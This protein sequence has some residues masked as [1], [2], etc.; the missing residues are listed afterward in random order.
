[1]MSGGIEMRKIEIDNEI[2]HF[3]DDYKVKV[4]EQIQNVT[5]KLQKLA[6]FVSEN[7]HWTD[8]YA[9]TNYIDMMI[10]DYPNLLVLEPKDWQ[11][12]ISKYSMVL[13][14]EPNMLIKEVN[15]RRK[16]DGI[17]YK[18]KFYERILE[19]LGY[20]EARLILGPIHQDMGL[21]TCVYCNVNPTLAVEGDVMYQMDHFMP[22]SKF[23]FLGTCF[24]NLQ[25]SCGICN[26]HKGKNIC[27]FGLYVNVEQNKNL[28]PFRFVTKVNNMNGAFPVCEEILFKGN[29]K[30]L[31]NE[32]KAHEK[33]FHIN[34]MYA[35]YKNKVSRLYSDAYKMNPAMISA[36]AASYEIPATKKNVLAYMSEHLSLD[37]KDIHENSLTKLKQDTIKQMEEGGAL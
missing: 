16:A 37:E 34:N 12:Y 6:T 17:F 26:G 23:P 35:G 36:F 18:G 14:R 8:R 4:E 20:E 27:D 13:G 2:R 15:Y 31:T 25:P 33:M 29:N 21:K 24:Y 3:A 22:Q 1:M 9:I 19:C 11:V 32:S 30:I 5:D 7:N 28:N 10:A